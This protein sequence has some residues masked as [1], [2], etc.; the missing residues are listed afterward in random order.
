MKKIYPYL[1]FLLF[2]TVASA[3][4]YDLAIAV[5]DPNAATYLE[6]GD[7]IRIGYDYHIAI[8]TIP[9]DPFKWSWGARVVNYSAND[10]TSSLNPR[11]HCQVK[12]NGASWGIRDSVFLSSTDTLVGQDRT[13]VI[14]AKSLSYYMLG[15]L[16]PNDILAPKTYRV[17]Y[18]V[19]HDGIETDY[20]NDTVHYELVME[21]A[22]YNTG[23]TSPL[24]FFYVS[25][26]LSKA[27]TSPVDGKVQAL[28]SFFPAETNLE[29]IEV[30][31]LYY[32]PDA[33]NDSL[34]ID[35][36]DFRYYVDPSFTGDT[37]Q[38]V[39]ASVYSFQDGVNGG[40]ADGQVEPSELV[41]HNILLDSITG[42][43]TRVVPGQYGL[44]TL[45]N[46]V[47]ASTGGT[48]SIIS[49][50]DF[51]LL[52]I[53]LQPSLLSSLTTVPA[54][55]LP[56]NSLSFGMDSIN[57]ALNRHQS[58]SQNPFFTSVIFLQDT[59]GSRIIKSLDN[60][61]LVPSIGLHIHYRKHYL[62]LAMEEKLPTTT[63]EVQLFPNPTS[64]QL[65]V[66]LSANTLPLE[67]PLQYIITDATGRVLYYT[68]TTPTFPSLQ[69]I[70]VQ[71]LPAGVYHL[72]LKSG[73]R[74]ST[75]AFI[76]Q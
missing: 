28:T 58:S 66:R 76:K 25:Q 51:C 8:P 39:L 13:G 46:F 41:L 17:S 43:G 52:T 44:K 74:K 27:R 22:Y 38:W 40:L 20:S 33:L 5:G 1:L 67:A 62:A 9:N 4:T 21:G 56:S 73:Q 23:L 2:G 53:W 71:S 6:Q 54:T 69:T 19:E 61:H 72:H 75:Q 30:G 42:V 65:Q 68:T 36:I 55:L 15:H 70:D 59:T 10:M 37:T 34:K 35:S 32:F 12:A 49:Y 11:L 48:Q 26:Y 16:Y 29:A 24:P 31:S 64:A 63:F 3:Q 7:V 57:Y 50:G 45:R 18:W 14:L 60:G 47:N